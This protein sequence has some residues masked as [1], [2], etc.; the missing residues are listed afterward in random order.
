MKNPKYKYTIVKKGKDQGDHRIE[1]HGLAAEFSL[2]EMHSA[3]KDAEAQ[4]GQFEGAMKGIN[5][6]I[7]NIREHHPDIVKL[8]AGLTPKKRHVL[9]EY[10]TRL[11]KHKEYTGALKESRQILK[12]LTDENKEVR[13][14]LKLK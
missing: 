2:R 7:R 13:K 12:R 8:V 9:L 14:V 4:V 1:K 6:I 5:V 11:K 3:I 10:A